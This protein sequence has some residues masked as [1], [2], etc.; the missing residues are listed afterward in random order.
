MTFSGRG[1]RQKRNG[2]RP[3]HHR[4]HGVIRRLRPDKRARC[5]AALRAR[6]SVALKAHCNAV[7]TASYSAVHCI[8]AMARYSGSCCCNEARHKKSGRRQRL[9]CSRPNNPNTFDPVARKA[10]VAAVQN[11]ATRCLPVLPRS[12]IGRILMY[13]GRQIAAIRP[14]MAWTDSHNCLVRVRQLRPAGCAPANREAF[15]V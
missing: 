10:V 1:G 3:H 4:R 6:C 5:S 7:L 9:R 15:P 13:L 11:D 14:R 8:E 2:R 12:W